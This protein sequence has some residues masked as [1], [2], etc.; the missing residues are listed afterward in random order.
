MSHMPASTVS[1]RLGM[2]NVRDY[3]AEGDGVADD[4]DAINATITAA[5]AYGGTD[6]VGQAIYFP[7]GKYMVGSTITPP[8]YTTFKGDSR[9]TVTIQYTGSTG[10][11]F[12]FIN[13][14]GC[15]FEDLRITLPLVTAPA[16]VTAFYMSNCFQFTFHRCVVDGNHNGLQSDPQSTG[17]ELRDNTG[18]C[19]FVACDINNFG[20]G[21]RTSTIQNFVQNCTL[22]GN[23]YGIYGDAGSFTAGMVVQSTT[24][25]GT[26]SAASTGV[27]EK[28]I[29]VDRTANMWRIIGCWFEGCRVGIQIGESGTGGPTEFGVI[30]CF[31]AGV[32]IGI[33]VQHVS[34][35]FLTNI[36]FA[37]DGTGTP[38]GTYADIKI[39]ATN[40]NNGICMGVRPAADFDLDP[41]IFPVGWVLFR[42]GAVVLPVA[43][44]PSAVT[45]KS[46]VSAEGNCTIGNST[47]LDTHVI[48]GGVIMNGAVTNTQPLQIKG[49]SDATG[50]IVAAINSNSAGAAAYLQ[51]TDGSTYNFGVGTDASGNLT[52]GTGKF[53]GSPGNVSFQI[54]QADGGVWCQ[55]N[56]AAKLAFY[57]TAP[58]AKQT[59]VA[60]TAAA[61]HAALVALGLI[62]A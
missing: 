8:D 26:G 12:E 49:T 54:D 51:F 22:S 20:A 3:G 6:V 4:T 36:T 11:L 14:F 61:I 62:A 25:V 47:S 55:P 33:D 45:F 56:A 5:R 48:N 15:G 40:A 37:T 59:G 57:G 60:V 24:F 58:I 29:V 21:I 34:R 18:D 44:F 16:T 23:K 39:D 17:F 27:S 30:G 7:P 28:H 13:K 9:Y 43:A 42:L 1:R 50:R 41:T 2:F 38:T 31:I 32:D 35:P 52:L 19:R 53:I 10:N 46:T